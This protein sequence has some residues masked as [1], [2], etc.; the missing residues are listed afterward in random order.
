MINAVAQHQRG[1]FVE[2]ERAYREVCIMALA[3]ND[4][5][6]KGVSCRTLQD[7]KQWRT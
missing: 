6:R 7:L 1:Q 5:R 4:L 3:V 2:A